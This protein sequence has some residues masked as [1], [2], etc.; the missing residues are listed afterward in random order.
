VLLLFDAAVEIP[1]VLAQPHNQVAW[2]GAVYNVTAIGACLMFSEFVI[3][4][5]QADQ[6]KN[7]VARQTA[8]RYPNTLSA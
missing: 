1:P 2:A 5:R 6:R 7:G 3:S 8:T 4:R